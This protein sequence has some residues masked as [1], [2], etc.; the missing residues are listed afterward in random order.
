MSIFSI[1]IASFK[2]QLTTPH[3]VRP[4]LELLAL[5]RQ[6][7]ALGDLDDHMLNDVGLTRHQAEAESRKPIWDSPRHWRS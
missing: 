3:V 2:S 5:H 7:R 6:R 4:L 1:R